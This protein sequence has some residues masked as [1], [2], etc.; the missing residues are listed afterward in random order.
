MTKAAFEILS[1][2]TWKA[3]ILKAVAWILGYRDEHA[4]VI[5]LNVDLNDIKAEKEKPKSD[6][7]SLLAEQ[8]FFEE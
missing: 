6:I 8:E 5:T 1:M 2:P 4:Y 7:N 3:K